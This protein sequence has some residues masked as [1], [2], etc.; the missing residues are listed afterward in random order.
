MASHELRRGWLLRDLPYTYVAFVWVAFALSI[1]IYFIDWSPVRRE[2][3]VRPQLNSV[4]NDN[5][6][7]LYTGSIII[8]P[9][10]GDL[11]WERRLDNRNGKM[12]DKGYVSC[13][14][15]ASQLAKN[16]PPKGIGAMRL[17]AIGK[18]L[19]HESD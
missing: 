3:A 15:V 4:N 6:D 18:A 16:N 5:N 17:R 1:L 10:R 9:T 7:K 14:K 19:L 8:V 2:T 13:Y 11:C 12:W